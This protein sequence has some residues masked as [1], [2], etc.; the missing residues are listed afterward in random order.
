MVNKE[1]LSSV[2]GEHRAGTECSEGL[3]QVVTKRN[4][5]ENIRD[6]WC[7]GEADLPISNY[8]INL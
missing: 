3:E 8:E 7:F 1:G 4:K 5:Q 6:Y 2:E